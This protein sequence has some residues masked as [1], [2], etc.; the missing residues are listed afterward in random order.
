MVLDTETIG[1][2]IMK[3]FN[4]F[5]E[6]SSLEYY[7]ESRLIEIGYIIYSHEGTKLSD[8]E[9]IIKPNDFIIKNHHI[10]GITN[11]IAKKKEKTLMMY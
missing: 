11:N 8:Y 7:K 2:P 10:H 5:Y 3:D 6:P 1:I 9:C 4:V